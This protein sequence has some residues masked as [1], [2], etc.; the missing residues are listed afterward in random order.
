LLFFKNSLVQP[1]EHG[2]IRNPEHPYSVKGV[3]PARKV[4]VFT[5]SAG[6]RHS[7]IS[8]A[9]EV[10]T[11]L[12]ERSGAFEAFATEEPGDL[13]PNGLREYAA[14]LFLT[15]GELPLTDEQ[16]LALIDY[17]KGGGGFVG[18]HNAADTF[19]NFREYGEMLGGYF[20]SHP[21]TQVVRV[22]VEDPNHPSTRHLPRTFEV[23]EEVYTFRDWSRAR[24]HALISLDTSSVDLSKG[25]RP[26]NDY[27]LAWCHSYG[28]G[29]VFYTA[30]GHF[31]WLWRQ[32]WFQKHLLGGILWAMGVA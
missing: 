29:R 25:T 28:S 2:Y 24:T 30:F 15:T 3:I 12:G 21:W 8:T 32:D 27:A 14:I 16:K 20:H 11:K 19:Y 10:I 7:Y 23:L 31:T 5:H 22:I 13:D 26:D 18:V 1:I 6:F 17:V 4:L 9:V